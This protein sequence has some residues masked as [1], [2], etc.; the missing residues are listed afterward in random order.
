[1]SRGSHLADHE[2][3]DALEGTLADARAA[4]VAACPACAA[5]LD[6]L[7]AIAAR[8]AGG[9]V[10][11]P[12]AF[13]WNQLSARV[14]AAV[15]EESPTARPGIALQWAWGGRWLRPAM[16][17]AAA[18]LIALGWTLSQGPQPAG[19]TAAPTVAM[20]T[21]DDA[22]L[23]DDV[24]DIEQDEAW[25]VVRTLAEDLDQ[26]QMDVEGVSA[27]PG[28]AEHLAQG[29]SDPERSELARLLAEQL[30]G[31]IIPETVS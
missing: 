25:A 11:E 5:Q 19:P 29:L 27:P 26:E 9:D 4:H 31:R 13:F 24:T 12:P 7:R 20:R 23:G 14:R 10:P 21:S 3:V 1:M 6:D 15:A 8:A 18:V 28:S 17:A 22:D 16:A 30:K 2:L